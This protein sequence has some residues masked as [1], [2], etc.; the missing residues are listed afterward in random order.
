IV[1]V[2]FAVVAAG[3]IGRMPGTLDELVVEVSVLGTD[4]GNL[5]ADAAA[6]RAPAAIGIAHDAGPN[7]QVNR[8]ALTIVYVQAAPHC[9]EGGA[10]IVRR[11]QRWGQKE[12]ALDSVRRQVFQGGNDNRRAGAMAQE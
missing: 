7:A 11:R 6:A 9:P 10:D 2:V 12:R 4:G 1:A 3:A 8:I 5:E